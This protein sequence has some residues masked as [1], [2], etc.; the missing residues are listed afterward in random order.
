MVEVSRFSQLSSRLI[1]DDILTFEEKP[2]KWSMLWSKG[3]I[4]V[5]RCRLLCP[6]IWRLINI[7]KRTEKD[8]SRKRWSDCFFYRILYFQNIWEKKE[9][10][11]GGG[12]GGT[13]KTRLIL[14][15]LNWEK[16]R[17]NSCLRIGL[18]TTKVLSN[19]SKLS[20][21]GLNSRGKKHVCWLDCLSIREI[22][23]L[24]KN[25]CHK[26]TYSEQSE[27]CNLG[28][29]SEQWIITERSPINVE[30]STLQVICQ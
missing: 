26:V 7:C 10:G 6:W 27:K 28:V 14:P 4:V 5:L 16:N 18:L 20:P 22:H 30:L 8:S 13:F 17:L 21:L 19:S 25:T 29:I 1:S 2:L 12:G 11:G 24:T 3:V 9:L 15:N 23:L